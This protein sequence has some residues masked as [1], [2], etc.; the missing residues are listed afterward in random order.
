MVFV[1]ELLVERTQDGDHFRVTAKPAS[2]DFAARF[3]RRSIVAI[4]LASE[5]VERPSHQ[6]ST[7]TTMK[8]KTGTTSV[9][10]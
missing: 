1:Y 7:P 4:S 6:N 9:S 8:N 10:R 2:D 5:R 3:P